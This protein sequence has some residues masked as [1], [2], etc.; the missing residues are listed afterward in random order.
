MAD[1]LRDR[2]SGVTTLSA[3]GPAV[4]DHPSRKRVADSATLAPYAGQ[5]AQVDSPVQ[6]DRHDRRRDEHTE[7]PEA[8]KKNQT[9]QHRFH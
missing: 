2:D 4:A 7:L 8:G 1:D 6:P 5:D 3:T 9:R